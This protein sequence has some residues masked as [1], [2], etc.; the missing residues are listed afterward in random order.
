MK[1]RWLLLLAFAGAMLVNSSAFTAEEKEKE[2]EAKCVVSGAPAKEDKFVEHNGKKV[3]F[4]CENCPKAFAKDPGKFTAKVNH[5]LLKTEQ[6]V[7]VACPFSGEALDPEQSMEIDGV[8]VAFCCEH[9]KAKAA[10]D[11]D[12]LALVFTDIEKGFTLQNLCPVSGAAIKI[13]NSVEH[14]G[15]K[16]YFC[17]DKCPAAFTKDPAKFL[18]KL[19]QFAEKEEK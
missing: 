1:T 6:I 2:F 10:D 12:A 8:K 4:C 19:P 5:Q 7:Q 17:C 15:K 14:D 3:Y 18:S 9:C 16:V 13:E 11:K